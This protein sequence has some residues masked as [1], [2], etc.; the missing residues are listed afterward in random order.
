MNKQNIILLKEQGFCYGVKRAIKIVQDAVSNQDIK[1]PIYLLGNLVH[2]DH[3]HEYLTTLGVVIIDGDNR[4][5]MLDQIPNNSTV[6]FS[7]HG[8]SD[9][10]RHKAKLKDLYIIDATCPYVDATFKL[11][12][13]ACINNDI[14]FIGKSNHPE[15]EAILELSNRAHLV[16]PNNLFIKEVDPNH[17]RVAHQTTMSCYDIDTL[18]KQITNVYPKAEKLDMICKVTEKRQIELKT[19]DNLEFTT[20]ALIIVVGDKKSNNS[21]KLY[22]L[23]LRSKKCDAVFI[24]SINELNLNDVRIYQTIIITSGTSTPPALINEIYDTLKNLDNI[25]EEYIQSKIDLNNLI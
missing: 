10:V 18:F 11:V 14:L 8:V 9:K 5:N 16:N 1:K 20:P 21:T 12:E 7:A 25:N 24:E 22:E 17:I 15:T 6:I 19:V 2:N 23:A 3:I 13:D 4:L